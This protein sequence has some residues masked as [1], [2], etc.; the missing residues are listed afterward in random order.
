MVAE[1][2]FAGLLVYSHYDNLWPI[3]WRNAP[4]ILGIV[5]TGI[6]G[7]MMLF[8]LLLGRFRREPHLVVCDDHID[9][10]H[11]LSGHFDTLHFNDVKEMVDEGDDDQKQGLLQLMFQKKDQRFVV[12]KMQP[13]LQKSDLSGWSYRLSKTLGPN[14]YG[15]S[16]Q[17]LDQPADEAYDLLRDRYMKY[18][19]QHHN[20]QTTN[21]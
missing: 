2:G 13:Y 15:I 5:F 6:P 17:G 11:A 8:M 1:L 14:N 16:L 3:T 10:Y 19:R 21:Y 12:F 7:L 9:V 20:P 4:E 18:C